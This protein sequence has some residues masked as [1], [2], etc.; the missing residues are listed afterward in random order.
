MMAPMK[1]RMLTLLVALA[2]LMTPVVASAR[3]AEDE[4]T[5]LQEARMEGYPQTVRLKDSSVAL[6]WIMTGFLSAMAIAVL[7][8]NPR[9]SHLD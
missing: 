2:L 6:T 9:R 4:D 7:F 3:Q 1:Q 8:K 5:V